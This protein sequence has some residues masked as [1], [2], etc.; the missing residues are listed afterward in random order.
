MKTKLFLVGLIIG[1]VTTSCAHAP[2]TQIVDVPVPV[3]AK[4]IDLKACPKVPIVDLTPESSW[5]QRLSAWNAT[6]VILQGCLDSRNQII[7][8][9]NKP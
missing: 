5:D 7:L 2:A 6:I 9:L 1:L 4:Q 3:H 8:E